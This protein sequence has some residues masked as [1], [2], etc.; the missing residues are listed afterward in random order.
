MKEQQISLIDDTCSVTQAR[1]LLVSFF[2]E[3]IKHLNLQSFIMKEQYGY[4]PMDYG[5]QMDKFKKEKKLVL[6]KLKSMNDPAIELEINC[7][8]ALKIKEKS[9]AV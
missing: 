1:E 8:A 4:D 5:R 2:D 6:E 7:V 3:K 9:L